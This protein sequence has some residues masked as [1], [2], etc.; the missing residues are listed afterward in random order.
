[1]ALCLVLVS[2]D[3]LSI[4]EIK[5]TVLDHDTFLEKCICRMKCNMLQF[6]I[7]PSM[8]CSKYRPYRAVEYKPTYRIFPVKYWY[9]ISAVA[10]GSTEYNC[11]Q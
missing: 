8:Y 2:N 11:V 5:T 7:Y 6:I 4:T 10:Y 9:L 1:M 3:W